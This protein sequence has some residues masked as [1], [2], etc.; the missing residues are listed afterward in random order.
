[1]GG[2][3]NLF[4]HALIALL[5]QAQVSESTEHR[6]AD[7]F[8]PMASPA[9]A[10]KSIGMLTIGI[11]A[12][13]FVVVAGLLVFTIWRFRRKAGD[14]T[15]QEPPQVYGS[16]QIEVAWT[17][18]P[19]LIVFVLI[20][21][22]ARVI[23][24]VENA[25]PPKDVTK[26]TIIGHQWWWE[27]HYPDYNFITANE[28]HVP[29]SPDGKKA[30]YLQLE[31]MDVIHSFWLPQLSGK[32]DLVPNRTNYMWIDPKEPGTY[33]GNCAEY[34]GTQHA[35]MMLR[36]IAQT[37]DDFKRWA[38]AQQQAAVSATQM[39]PDRQVFESLS[40]VNCHAIKGTVA[41]GRF[42]P[43][44]THLMSRQ[45]LGAGV[46]DND[47]DHLKEWVN[48]PQDPKP[49][50]YMP[51]LKLTDQELTQVVSYLQTLK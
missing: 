41:V 47:K 2:H 46:I 40:C 48:N 15:L 26:V 35:N 38:Q 16:N 23:A 34:C 27:V 10:E 9:E 5:L 6:V 21:V 20:G 29:S 8:K 37:P 33:F 51:S 45:T 32:T 14:N 17:V 1:M 43:D 4:G 49:G 50:C 22:S 31:S 30:T 44:L 39:T 13:I 42:G 11:T 18:I 19:V 3:S 12:G 28:I 36:V 7:I 24:G 25:S